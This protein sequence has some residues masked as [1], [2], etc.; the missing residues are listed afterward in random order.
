MLRALRVSASLIALL[1][2]LTTALTAP[3]A[4][5]ATTTR[6]PHVV[7]HQASRCRSAS[8]VP[9]P[10]K[11]ACNT[12]KKILTSWKRL[13][14]KLGIKL[15]KKRVQELDRK[16]RDGMIKVS[17]LPARLRRNFPSELE[18]WDLNQIINICNGLPPGNGRVVYT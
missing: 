18:P 5:G 3:G 15:S 13:A 1:L 17:D 8:A 16:T 4:R 10:G 11:D 12:A 2:W 9:Y 14:Q 6:S 7:V